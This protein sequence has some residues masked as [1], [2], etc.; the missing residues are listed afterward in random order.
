MEWST[1]G[2]SLDKTSQ[3]CLEFEKQNSHLEIKIVKGIDGSTIDKNTVISSG[4]ANED[5][6]ETG[7]LT[8][9]RL[10]CAESHRKILQSLV[11]DNKPAL[12]LE[13]DVITHPKIIEFINGNFSFLNSIDLLFFTINTDSILETVSPQGLNKV[14]IFN[15]KH[16]TKEWIKIALEHTHLHQIVAEKFCKGFS[17]AAYFA[18]PN[19]A[20]KLLENAFPFNTETVDIP[21]INNKMLPTSID[22]SFN[23]FYA[24]MNVFITVPFLA[25]TP[26]T[27]SSTEEGKGE[28]NELQKRI[29]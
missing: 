1:Y 12:I 8:S 28:Y 26:N 19:G 29:I 14:S 15:P 3:R 11:S 6:I 23:K 2:I 27:N 24:N 16:P 7:L 18:T 25:Y 5:L 17:L 13:D 22:R 21:L 9:G 10:G 4:L 20:T